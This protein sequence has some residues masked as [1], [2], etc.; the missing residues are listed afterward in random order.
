MQV[1]DALPYQ[2]GSS[3]IRKVCKTESEYF[4]RTM[5]DHLHK[6]RNMEDNHGPLKDPKL[7][8]QHPAYTTYG[9]IAICDILHEEYSA[10]KKLNTL[11]ERISYS[12]HI[13]VVEEI[14]SGGSL[15]FKCQS[16]THLANNLNYSNYNS[17]GRGGRGSTNSSITDDNGAKHYDTP[18]TTRVA[19]VSI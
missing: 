1:E 8:E 10:L 18:A 19:P 13:S 3:L 4:N 6:A 2:T 5:Y 9:P 12:N 7:L 14:N 16:N 11:E 15:Y 17:D